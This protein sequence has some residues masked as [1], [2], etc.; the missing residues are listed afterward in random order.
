MRCYTNMFHVLVSN[1]FHNYARKQIT[2][3]KTTVGQDKANKSDV[4]DDCR[5]Q[6]LSCRSEQ[7]I[8]VN[9]SLVAC[10]MT[11]TA[12]QTKQRAARHC[13]ISVNSSSTDR[14][15]PTVGMEIPSARQE[16][17]DIRSLFERRTET[18]TAWI[19]RCS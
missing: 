14:P 12:A 8:N 11:K 10:C 3:C 16:C 4:L 9:Y 7:S 6:C 17:T 15:L 19:G 18:L 5:Q 2:H 13:P 1:L